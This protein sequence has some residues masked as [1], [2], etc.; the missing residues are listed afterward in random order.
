[1]LAMGWR[2]LFGFSNITLYGLSVDCFRPATALNPLCPH[3]VP[4][5]KVTIDGSTQDFETEQARWSLPQLSLLL[6]LVVLMAA[7]LG[8]GLLPVVASVV[9]TAVLLASL[10]PSTAVHGCPLF[11]HT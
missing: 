3:R 8:F 1:M 10:R 6:G 2:S 5:A 4:E 11:A 9:I 7:P